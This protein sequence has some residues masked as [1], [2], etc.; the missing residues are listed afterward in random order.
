MSGHQD[1]LGSG[2]GCLQGARHTAATQLVCL[3]CLLVY[4]S[5][6][7]LCGTR[8][9]QHSINTCWRNAS[10]KVVTKDVQQGVKTM[11]AGAK[12]PSVT[13]ASPLRSVLLWEVTS[14]LW[15]SFTVSAFTQKKGIIAM[16]TSESGCED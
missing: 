11:D 16:P 8:S 3:F 13:L 1:V 15:A 4:P 5:L 7:R 9:G 6:W 12:T 10:I 14:H 2:G